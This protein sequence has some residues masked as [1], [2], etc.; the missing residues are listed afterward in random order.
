MTLPK[1]FYEATVKLVC[2][3]CG[4]TMARV[5]RKIVP[6]T[7]IMCDHWKYVNRIT[8][9]DKLRLAHAQHPKESS[10]RH[11]FKETPSV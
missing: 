3:A 8:Y 4:Q 5:G 2:V 11:L 1:R 9:S 10:L 6:A 7:K